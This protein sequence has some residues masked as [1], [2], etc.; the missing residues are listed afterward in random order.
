MYFVYKQK[1]KPHKLRKYECNNC[2][3]WQ[4]IS[5]KPQNASET[6]ALT[7]CKHT[8][9]LKLKPVWA[10][11]TRKESLKSFATIDIVFILIRPLVLA[12]YHNENVQNK[13]L[14]QRGKTAI[15]E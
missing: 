3:L 10:R 2:F 5:K 4:S 15:N 14:E 1:F 7:R 11:E 13:P 9:W 8:D 12:I 6:F